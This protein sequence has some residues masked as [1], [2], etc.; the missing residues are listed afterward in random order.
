MLKRTYVGV[1]ILLAAFSTD[2]YS[3]FGN[4]I[5]GFVF[6]LKRVPVS[7]ANVELLDEYNR[8]VTRTRTSA[9]GRYTF[10]RLPAGRF[11]VRT[12]SVADY[13]D[14][15]QEVE[16]V[17]ITTSDNTGNVR[18]GAFEN[19]QR[20]FYLRPRKASDGSVRAAAVFAQE[21][22]DQARTTFRAA[23]MDLD[24]GDREKGLQG[25]KRSIE[26]FPDYFDALE[27]LGTEYIKDRHF[28]PAQLLLTRATQINPRSFKAW[29]GLAFAHYSL[30][31]FDEAASAADKAISFNPDSVEAHMIAGVANRQLRKFEAAET[32]LKK[33][34][35]LAGGKVP[36][37]HWHLALIYGN[38]LKKYSEAADELEQFLKLSP[39]HKDKEHVRKLI[40]QFREKAK[41]SSSR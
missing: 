13:E 30:T 24:V 3:Q 14:Q 19:V 15:E 8:T 6:G 35:A 7:D 28:V 16:I 33:A 4:T 32:L 5:N 23:L 41:Q 12:F 31:N 36:E 18:T 22:P 2:A 27:L 20:D 38:D 39:N 25:V 37:V 29:Y 17:N 34:D 26:I 10:G 11:R 40:E 21:V 9:S 1:L